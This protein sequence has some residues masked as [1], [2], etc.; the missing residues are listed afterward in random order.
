[1]PFTAVYPEVCS[2]LW[3]LNGIAHKITLDGEYRWVQSS[4]N[5]RELPLLDRLDDDATDQA[6]RDLRSFNLM[7]FGPFPTDQQINGRS[8]ATLS[9]YDPQLYALRRGL[10]TN[11]D[12]LDD[13]QFLTFGIHQRLQT[14]RGFPGAQHI[15]DW[16]TLNVSATY[17]PESDRDNFGESFGYLNYDYSW[18][19]GDRTTFLSSGWIDPFDKGGRVFNAGF[20]LERPERIRYYFGYRQIDPV[21][22]QAFI[23]SMTYVFSPKYV[24]TLAS[25]YDFGQSQ[26][27][28][29]TFILTRIGSDVQVSF[30]VTYN[31]LQN[32]FGLTFEIVP[33]LGGGTRAGKGLLAA[34]GGAG[35]GGNS[36]VGR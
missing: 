31:A 27:L 2:Q 4:E 36:G 32:D 34:G 26:N 16:M 10:L 22:S 15:I 12:N 23:G 9:I 21:G 11:V 33:A 19:I 3:N 17:F 30:G 5:F 8:L 20:F 14:K 28:G 1:M 6:R 7:P 24:V 29:N 35:M 13:L 18:H 25:T